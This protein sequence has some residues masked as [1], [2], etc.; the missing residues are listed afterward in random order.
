MLILF[1]LKDVSE[2]AW[3]WDSQLGISH[4]QPG[5]IRIHMKLYTAELAHSAHTRSSGESFPKLRPVTS[6]RVNRL[7]M[8]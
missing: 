4:L 1:K 2:N 3:E 7:D 6:R 8:K 5:H